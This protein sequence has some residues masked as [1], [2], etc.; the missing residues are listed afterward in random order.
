[1]DRSQDIK[2]VPD[3]LQEVNG[4][5]DGLRS[6]L[7]IF[8][9]FK[10]RRPSPDVEFDI[11]YMNAKL[12]FNNS[13]AQLSDAIIPFGESP[14]RDEYETGVHCRFI[15]D[16]KALNIIE[17]T[18]NGDVVFVLELIPVIVIKKITTLQYDEKVIQSTR[19]NTLNK[20]TFQFSIPK[21][22]WV[23]KILKSLGLPGFKL[24]EIPL[25]HVNL[26][27]AY[28]NI[29]SEFNKAEHYF[30]LHDYNKCISHCRGTM[31]ALTR[32]LKAIKENIDSKS[33]FKWFNSVDTATL[34]W[35]D[36]MN[37]S[38]SAISSIT[39]H[40]ESNKEFS[41]HEAQSIYLITLGLM[42]FVGH[43]NKG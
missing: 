22:H 6:S 15:L 25:S 34:N 7:N 41:R 39:H 2:V 37:K 1:M 31:D 3:N 28:D 5:Y 4:S 17:S 14:P 30:S 23:E 43:L 38:T 35:I 11:L 10:L 29:I 8:L 40:S 33:S 27:E 21:S 19:T 18:R 42:N 26:A 20:I 32:S 24:I 13:N 16:D 36:E 12:K 9:H